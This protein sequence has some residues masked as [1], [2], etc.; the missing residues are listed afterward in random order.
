[1]TNRI[2]IVGAFLVLIGLLA[3][4]SAMAQS[5]SSSPA[6][7]TTQASGSAGYKT[8]GPQ[9]SANPGPGNALIVGLLVVAVIA[10]VF[11]GFMYQRSR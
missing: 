7:T 8:G 2:P 4:S 3:A 10:L 11:A 1:M 6:P 5:Y 9:G